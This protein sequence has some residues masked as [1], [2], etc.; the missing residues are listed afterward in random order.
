MKKAIEYTLIG[1]VGVALSV[2][3]CNYMNKDKEDYVEISS[4][5]TTKL[6]LCWAI[7]AFAYLWWREY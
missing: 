3:L 7:P 1:T 4:G 5:K 2:M 6:M